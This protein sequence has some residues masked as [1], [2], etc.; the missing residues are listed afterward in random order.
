MPAT[1]P[2]TLV[3]ETACFTCLTGLQMAQ[4]LRI[5]LEIRTLLALD[6]YADVT[7]AGLVAYAKCFC[8]A[9]KTQ[10]DLAELALLDKISQA[11]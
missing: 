11:V 6:P 5:A 3:A 10:A 2:A 1:P 7:P 8:A 9:A 4:R